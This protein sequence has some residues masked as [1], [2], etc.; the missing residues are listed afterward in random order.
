MA[1]VS[2]FVVSACQCKGGK[3]DAVLAHSVHKKTQLKQSEMEHFSYK[4]Y[5]YSEGFKRR[6]DTRKRFGY[7][8]A[9]TV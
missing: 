9:T 4:A 3:S 8:V 5:T 1:L 6:V 7:F 2:R